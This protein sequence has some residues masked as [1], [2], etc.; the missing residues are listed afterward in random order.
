MIHA[1]SAVQIFHKL[2]RIVWPASRYAAEA[3]L[4]GGHADKWIRLFDDEEDW[5]ELDAHVQCTEKQLWK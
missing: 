5:K 2:Y 1:E 4:H 3:G